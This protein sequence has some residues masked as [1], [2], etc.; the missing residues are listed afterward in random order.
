M[1]QYEWQLIL[2]RGAHWW[3]GT[4]FPTDRQREHAR[5]E[6]FRTETEDELTKLSAEGWRIVSVVGAAPVRFFQ[7]RTGRLWQETFNVFLERQVS[8][9]FTVGRVDGARTASSTHEDA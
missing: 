9:G 6:A 7:N 8:D 2:L 1:V 4:L 3:E 5:A